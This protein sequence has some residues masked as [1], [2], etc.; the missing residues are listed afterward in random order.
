MDN[1]ELINIAKDNLNRILSYFPRTD[2]LASFLGA[3]NLGLI[4]V[5]ATNSPSIQKIGW[6]SAILGIIYLII[7]AISLGYLF[8]AI[9]PNLNGDGDSLIFF[10]EV[11]R[12][13][14]ETYTEKFCQQVEEQYLQDLTKQIW[15]NSTILK[16]KF[17]YL[18]MSAIFL[19]LS[20]IL[21]LI[22][23]TIFI[24]NNTDSLLKK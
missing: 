2:T 19:I 10:D 7:T 16:Q 24:T 11:A 3:I 23:L 21:G 18:Q 13:S 15:F 5:I 14:S 8:C 6:S 20:F 1:K 4:L 22:L 17:E 12:K 9:F